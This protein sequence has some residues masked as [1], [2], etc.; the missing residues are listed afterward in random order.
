MLGR[1]KMR[2]G[3]EV[4]PGGQAGGTEVNV[5]LEY[6]AHNRWGLGLGLGVLTNNPKDIPD[7]RHAN[8]KNIDQDKQDQGYG[9]M[10]RPAEVPAWEEQLLQ[11]PA[12]LWSEWDTSQGPSAAAPLRVVSQ[13]EPHPLSI[14]L[15]L[16]LLNEPPATHF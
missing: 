1:M 9:H 7:G 3:A 13:P 15:H 6:K 2:L 4:D 16:Y 14:P 11:G 10:S 8:D 12:D 5:S